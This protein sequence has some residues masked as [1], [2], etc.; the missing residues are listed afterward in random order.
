MIILD[1]N[2]ISETVRPHP[3]P[4]VVSWFRRQS[5][6]DLAVTSITVAELFWGICRMPAGKRRNQLSSVID[7]Q[8]T[9]F[10]DGIYA[11]D[12]SAAIDYAEICAMRERSGHPIG[13]QD[14]M[15]AAIAR[16]RGAAVAT[17]N[18]KDFE[19]TGVDVVNPWEDA[20]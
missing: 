20:G 15:I 9:L 17:R 4:E 2:V 1:T 12:G 7:Y 11:F 13:V 3:N 10:G 19:G 18:V 5:M 14:A 16:S 6:D 8:L